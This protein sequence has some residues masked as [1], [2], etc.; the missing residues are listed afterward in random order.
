MSVDDL[1]LIKELGKGTFAGIY[2]ASK[3]GSQE[4]F[5]VK[6]IDKRYI[7]DPRA[8][9]FIDRVGFSISIVGNGSTWFKSHIVSP[10]DISG[11]PAIVTI[12]P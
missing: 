1:T 9:K 11:H 10:I 5:A 12:S 3:Q 7:A 6:E 4:K 8:K 2:L